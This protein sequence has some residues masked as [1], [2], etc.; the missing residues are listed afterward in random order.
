MGH[1][2][3]TWRLLAQALRGHLDAASM[4]PGFGRGWAYRL[5]P[6]DYSA[7]VI[8]EAYLRNALD[9]VPPAPPPGPAGTPNLASPFAVAA[10]CNAML[11]NL[12][13]D[14]TDPSGG[15]VPGRG[16]LYSGPASHT[17]AIYEAAA[18]LAALR[19]SLDR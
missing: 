16:W 13:Q 9:V 3:A 6:I 17:L 1:L 8:L 12:Q 11:A 15:H 14:E 7:I 19:N 18:L 5:N 2:F 10:D 4:T